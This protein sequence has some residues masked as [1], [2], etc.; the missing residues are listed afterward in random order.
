VSDLIDVI[1]LLD[2]ELQ[3]KNKWANTIKF[4]SWY[5]V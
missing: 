5:C 3:D 1:V 4:K 2:K